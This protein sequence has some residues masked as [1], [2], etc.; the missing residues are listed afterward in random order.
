MDLYR[1]LYGSSILPG[2]V[3]INGQL[4][5]LGEI[6]QAAHKASGLSVK[7]WNLLDEEQREAKLER[8]I[9]LMRNTQ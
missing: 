1:T 9:T 5:Q 2:H 6:V 7:D 3:E 4:V 8:Q